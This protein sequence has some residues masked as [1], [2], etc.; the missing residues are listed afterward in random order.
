MKTCN[1]VRIRRG[2]TECKSL[3]L[4]HIEDDDSPDVIV[5]QLISIG[6]GDCEIVGDFPGEWITCFDVQEDLC[7]AVSSLGTIYEYRHGKWSIIAQLTFPNVIADVIILDR[8]TY[9][10][11]GQGGLIGEWSHDGFVRTRASRRVDLIS[12][13]RDEDGGYLICGD[14]GTILRYRDNAVFSED[15]GTREKL[16]RILCTNAGLSFACG[17]NGAL[18]RRESGKWLPMDS[19]TDWCL[20]GI[21]ITDHD[22]VY[23]AGGGLARVGNGTCCVEIDSDLTNTYLFD[24]WKIRDE[25]FIVTGVDQVLTGPPW[26][27]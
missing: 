16:T 21:A 23:V 25:Q 19:G 10:I 22:Q 2:L 17:W 18:I 14:Q 20:T 24:I 15:A 26:K 27:V 7:V 11:A 6:S 13:C 4:A 12:I 1:Y 8:G 9:L 3:V 5:S